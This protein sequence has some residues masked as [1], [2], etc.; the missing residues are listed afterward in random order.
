MHLFRSKCTNVS[1]IK[2]RALTQMPH[3]MNAGVALISITY[4]FNFVQRIYIC[5]MQQDELT[6]LTCV[7]MQYLL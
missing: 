2:L 1:H 6:L 3:K 5:N 7:F 4:L